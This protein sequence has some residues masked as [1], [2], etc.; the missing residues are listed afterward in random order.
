[1]NRCL[2]LLLLSSVLLSAVT[3]SAQDDAT[4]EAISQY[5]K[6][7]A[8]VWNNH[9]HVTISYKNGELV[10]ESDVH[11]ERLILNKQAAAL[12]STDYVYHSYFHPLKGDIEAATLIPDGDRYRSI[13]ATDMKTT[14]S[15][16][17]NVF[18][19]DTKVTK[20]TFGNI[21]QYTRTKLDY[22]IRHR[23]IHF[24]PSFIL[25]AACLSASLLF[26]LLPPK[27]W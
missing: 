11:E 3:A 13:P 2:Y 25:R 21:G 27:A 4:K 9:E 16:G 1:M 6:E 17:E 26:L 12:Y 7:N 5:P 8:I 20:I 19:D 22:T 14:H 23:D 15:E 24:L 18:Y 10:S